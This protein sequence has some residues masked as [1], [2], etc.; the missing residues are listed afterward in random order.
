MLLW[1]SL[2][3]VAYWAYYIWNINA[4]FIGVVE[5]RTHKLSAQESG[6]VKKI[7]VKL[8]EQVKASQVLVELADEDL[9]TEETWL[10]EEL[11]RL[12]EMMKAD[13]SR[14]TLEYEKLLMQ[15]EA[16]AGNIGQ[17]RSDLESKKAELE[18]V[19]A[20]IARLNEMQKSGLG[21]SKDLTDLNIRRD[22]LTR[23]I[24]EQSA[25]LKDKPDNSAKRSNASS[26][27]ESER[28]VMSMLSERLDR[29]NEIQLQLK[30]IATRKSNRLVISPCEGCIVNVNYLPG[31]SAKEFET[32]L[33]V[34]EPEAEFMDVYIPETS[35]RVPLLGERV[36]I[37]PHRN[38]AVEAAG[39]VVFVDPGYSAVPDR[40]AFRNIIYWA[41][42]FRVKLDEGHT[43]M[44]GEAAKVEMSASML[45]FNPV[46]AA[47]VPNSY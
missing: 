46:S 38:G 18:A 9:E 2:A 8:G 25:A 42:K 15:S 35:D 10:K 6:R 24:A 20:E 16:D 27:Q 7:N 34:E 12:E 31:D 32:I 45:G 29:M 26:G 11:Q 21:R 23:F 39:V 14:Y 30:I 17:R 44:P 4:D 40:L 19:N 41:R 22:A 33:T 36:T 5:T 1:I 28:V 3:L 43:L 37:Y 47:T 13:R